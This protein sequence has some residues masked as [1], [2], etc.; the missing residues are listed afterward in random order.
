MMVDHS[1]LPMENIL[2][3][4]FFYTAAS[5]ILHK[6]LQIWIIKFDLKIKEKKS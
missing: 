6:F 5:D 4:F 3:V 1:C 2:D